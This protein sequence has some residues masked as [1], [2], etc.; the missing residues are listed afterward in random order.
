MIVVYVYVLKNGRLVKN[1]RIKFILQMHLFCK[2]KPI[3]L[4]YRIRRSGRS[5]LNG[6]LLLDWALDYR[7]WFLPFIDSAFAG[8]VAII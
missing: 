4:K 6:N 7:Y 3:N 2:N 8:H 5:S 1:F